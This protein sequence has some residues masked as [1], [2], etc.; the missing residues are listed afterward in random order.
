MRAE[1]SAIAGALRLAD[2]YELTSLHA[3]LAEVLQA[4]WPKSLDEWDLGLQLH[5]YHYPQNHPNVNTEY[6]DYPG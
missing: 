3:K 1:A 5:P 4:H 2:K 6:S